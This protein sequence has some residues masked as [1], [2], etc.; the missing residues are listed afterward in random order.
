MVIVSSA[1]QKFAHVGL[2][3][4]PEVHHKKPLDLTH[5]RFENRSRTTR[6]RFLQSF[7]LHDKAVQLQLSRRNFHLHTHTTQHNTTKHCNTTQHGDRERQRQR[8]R[9]RQRETV[10]EDRERERKEDERQ[11]T[12][13]DETRQDKTRQQTIDYLQRDA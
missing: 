1:Y 11:Q 13:R 8:Q 3:R 12:R 4:A 5:L 6:S 9:Q 10:K 2:S 7:A